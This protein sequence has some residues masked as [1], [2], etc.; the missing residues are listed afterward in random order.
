MFQGSQSSCGIGFRRAM[1]EERQ[2][3]IYGQQRLALQQPVG[4]RHISTIYDENAKERKDSKDEERSN[5][6]R[7][8]SIASEYRDVTDN[9]FIA[10]TQYKR[11]RFVSAG[12][13]PCC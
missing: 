8:R 13:Q 2:K 12:H 6:K 7:I 9:Q 10:N 4:G 1:A 11:T 3:A 5:S